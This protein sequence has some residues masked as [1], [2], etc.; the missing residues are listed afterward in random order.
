MEEWVGGSPYETTDERPIVRQKI[1][2]FIQKIFHND[3][4][5]FT[6]Q[7]ILKLMCEAVRLLKKADLIETRSKIECDKYK[8]T[9]YPAFLWQEKYVASFYFFATMLGYID[10]RIDEEQ[11]DIEF[12]KRFLF[13]GTK[14]EHPYKD[15]IDKSTCKIQEYSLVRKEVLDGY[16]AIMRKRDSHSDVILET[17]ETLPSYNKFDSLYKNQKEW[18]TQLYLNQQLINAYNLGYIFEKNTYDEII[19]KY[20]LLYSELLIEKQK[21]ESMVFNQRQNDIKKKSKIR[22]N[23]S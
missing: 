11:K 2:Y 4:R 7:D 18:G 13:A 6:N 21:N 16:K 9:S 3:I 20:R 23:K 10:K 12:N 1:N 17:L 19:N 15:D 22:S 8:T 5:V 14:K